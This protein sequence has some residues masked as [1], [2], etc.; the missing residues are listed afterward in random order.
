MNTNISFQYPAW[1]AIL[2]LLLGIGYAIMM[3]YGN[4]TFREKSAWLNWLLG[5]ARAA[6]VTFLSLLLLSPLLK[7]LVT[8]T[9]KPIIVVAQDNSESIMSAMT[10][11]DSTRYRE[12]LTDLETQLG[13][14]YDIKT[15][16][17]GDKVREGFDFT[18]KDKVSNTSEL[19]DDLYET[20]S[21]QN[22]G[23]I[24]LATDGIY[25]QGSNPMYAGTKLSVP[26]YAVALGDTIAK[27]DISI[28]K[29]YHN[30]I[31][32]LG[33]KF[34]IQVDVAA[35]NCAGSRSKVKIYKVVDD[36]DN[37]KLKE[38]RFKIKTN[39]FFTTKE[40]I[41]EAN[42]SGVQ[43]YRISIS[44]V[45]DEV[46]RRN[47]YKDIFIDVLDARQKILVLAD[48]PHPDLSAIKQTVSKNKNYQVDIAYA[49][50]LKERITKYDF[51]V[52]HQ[53]PSTRNNAS[54]IIK[55]LDSRKIPRLYI[56]GSQTNLTELGKVQGVFTARGSTRN[57]NDVAGLV[58]DDFN[59]FTL[60]DNI[61]NEL[62][63][64]APLIAPF[65]E[66][67]ASAE[68]QVLLYQ[69]IGS[70]ET[71]YPL[72]AFG[73]ERDIKIGVLAGEGIWK[74]RIFDYLQHKNHDIFDEV[75]SKTVQY[76]T[77]K[78]DK[79][80]FRTSVSKNIFDENEAIYFDAELYNESYE[81]INEPDASLTITDSDGKNYNFTF[82][83][84]NRAYSLNA[85]YFPVGNY[86]YKAR[87][88]TQGKELTSRGK[89]SV[90]PIELESFETTADHR[91]LRLL[92]EQY[93]GQ[94]VYP[95]SL[96]ALPRILN[97]KADIQPVLYSTSK[98]RSIINLKWIFWVLLGL[99][100][101]EWFFRKFYGGY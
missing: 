98:T 3:Y 41:L 101:V 88:T 76:L 14:Q 90:Q 62:P 40:I 26:V 75:M 25:N 23:A 2:C 61:A 80:K 87:I 6:T 86:K 19:L 59:L 13:E 84:T 60:N 91:L 68:S 66:F 51:V 44:S 37:I 93:G 48:A 78:E 55:E 49:G 53:L 50:S 7:S 27:R 70:V 72:L 36:G 83:K 9:K 35:R 52:L 77:V 69:K 10:S 17:F 47:N 56:I 73:E 22:L 100:G 34:S 16:S 24:V 31:A 96:S 97:A 28:K 30:R 20:Y 63:K 82:S 58:A 38:E 79:R 12:Q 5:F 94:V 33:D 29:V 45:K 4:R 57:T 11:E 99:L 39:D 85:G 95:D 43:R 74:W 18:F 46:T 65:G 32:Y 64:F 8:E 67:S 42:S 21:N 81:L 15:Y 92:S 89:F 71:K 54:S 1:F